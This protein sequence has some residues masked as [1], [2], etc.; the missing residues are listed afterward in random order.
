M[1]VDG[2]FWEGLPAD[3]PCATRSTMNSLDGRPT[4]VRT[5]TA[6]WST[7]VLCRRGRPIRDVP[8]RMKQ[9][10]TSAFPMSHNRVA[11]ETSTVT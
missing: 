10:I 7:V 9:A 3:L 2:S 6:L 4:Q 8:M 1:A 5:S 11:V